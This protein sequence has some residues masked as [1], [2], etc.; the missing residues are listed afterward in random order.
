[1]I[2]WIEIQSNHVNELE[3]IAKE[4]NM[5]PLALEDCI[6]RNQ[7]AKLEDYDTHQLLVWFMM[8]AGKLYEMQFVV[9]SNH[10]IMVPHDPPPEGKTWKEYFKI[11]ESHKDVWHLLYQALDKCTDV[12]WSE[13]RRHF[14]EIDEFEE[15][16]FTTECNPQSILSLKKHLLRIDYSIGHLA[17]VS[18]QL[19]NFCQPKD[20][21]NWKLRDLHDHCERIYRSI[22]LYRSQIATTIELFWGYQSHKTNKHIKKLS[23][24]ASIAVPLT[25]WASFWGMNFEAIPFKSQSI[26]YLALGIMIASVLLS[27]WFLK[28]RGYWED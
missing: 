14:D 24:L 28:S 10:L 16:I 18:Q 13:V 21:L 23:V 27:A 19:Q 4:S 8:A 20:D 15:K 22:A 12:T 6:H 17:S 7:R 5:H 26:F 25:F 3:M 1:M 9:F 2:R 11:S